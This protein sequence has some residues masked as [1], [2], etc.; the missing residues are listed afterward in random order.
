MLAHRMRS[1][2]VMVCHRADIICPSKGNDIVRLCMKRYH[3]SED[4]DDVAPIMSKV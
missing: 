1:D 4:Y 3:K 2:T